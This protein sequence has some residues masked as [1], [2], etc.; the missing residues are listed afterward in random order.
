MFLTVRLPTHDPPPYR[1]PTLLYPAPPTCCAAATCTG[2]ASTGASSSSDAA[3]PPARFRASCSARTCRAAGGAGRE[4]GGPVWEAGRTCQAA[5][6]LRGS[7]AGRWA[8]ADEAW[9]DATPRPL[10][11]AGELHGSQSSGSALASFC[12]KYWSPP[13]A[14]TSLLPRPAPPCLAPPPPPHPAAPPFAAAQSR[15]P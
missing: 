12:A 6:G 15:G 7:R 10:C 3:S 11:R 2:L 14:Q 1:L 5:T 9:R 4:A 13:L 8:S